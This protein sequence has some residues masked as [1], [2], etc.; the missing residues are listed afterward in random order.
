MVLTKMFK[1][2]HQQLQFHHHY[3]VSKKNSNQWGSCNKRKQ[4]QTT[5]YTYWRA[6][7]DPLSRYST[8]EK[9]NKKNTRLVQ[10]MLLR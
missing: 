2:K 9:W 1:I 10:N 3:W 5:K 4:K 6:S 8:F 7:K